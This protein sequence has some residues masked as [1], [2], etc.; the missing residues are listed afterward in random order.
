MMVQLTDTIFYGVSMVCISS[1]ATLEWVS[2]IQ[3][4]S[5]YYVYVLF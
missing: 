3:S 2:Q 5:E 4:C 1:L